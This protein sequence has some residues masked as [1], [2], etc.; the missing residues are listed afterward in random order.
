MLMKRTG[1]TIGR[2]WIGL[3]AVAMAGC[4]GAS[5]ETAERSA[6]SNA[7]KATVHAYSAPALGSDGSVNT[8]F[9]ETEH[10]VIVVDGLRTLHEGRAGLT[11]LR[12]IGKPIEAIVLTH[13]HPDHVG[14]LGVFAAAAPPGTP[15]YGSSAT[16]AEIA[17]DPHHYYALSV[18]TMPGDFPEKAQVPTALVSDGQHVT[19]DGVELVFSELGAGES[20]SAT[21]VTIPAARSAFVGDLTSRHMSP[22][23]IEG[24]TSAWLEQLDALEKTLK[25]V[26]RVYPG[27]GTDSAATEAV[28]EQRVYLKT[29]RDLVDH[30]RTADGRVEPDGRAAIRAGLDT[31]FRGYPPVASIPD[32]LDKNIDSVAKELAGK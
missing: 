7:P 32:M 10:G 13:S 2:V 26:D 25:G 21:V 29:F 4:S 19:I 22:Y 11:E 15:V 14:G 9:L 8:Y 30:H 23:L 12:K 17:D 18:S 24:R 6:T 1:E 31:A 28:A 3:V 27:H 5:T 16:R 20:V